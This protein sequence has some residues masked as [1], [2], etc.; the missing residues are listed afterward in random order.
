MGRFLDKGGLVRAIEPTPINRLLAIAGLGGILAGVLL[1][2]VLH[3]VPPSDAV[4]PVSRTI[5]EYAL[6]DNGW[7]FVTAVGILAAG[8]AAVLVASVLVGLVRVDSVACVTLAAWCLGLAGVILFPK[9]NW[10]VGP[11]ASG[12]VH[13]VASLIAFLSLPVAAILVGRAWRDHPRW[14]AHATTILCLGVVSLL[15]FSPIAYAILTEPLT[16]VRWW[17]AIPLGAVERILALSE[18]ITV[19][20]LGWWSAQAG[21][22]ASVAQPR[23]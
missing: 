14:H 23:P 5:S 18:V 12:D 10:S 3:V 13:R 9:H 19:L 15:S 2:G 16:G 21:R 7:V 1:V 6:L 11:S 4:S 17:R 20:A 8:S 22:T